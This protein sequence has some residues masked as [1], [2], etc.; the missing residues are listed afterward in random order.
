MTSSGATAGQE[1][2]GGAV[3]K[4]IVDLGEG[5]MIWRGNCDVLR[6][7]KGRHGWRGWGWWE[8][9]DGSMKLACV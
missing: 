2:N 4:E 1:G 5:K 6:S 7:H 8:G 3:H 9:G